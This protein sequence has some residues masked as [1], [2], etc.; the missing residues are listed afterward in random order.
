MD[1]DFLFP[2]PP[3]KRDEQHLPDAIASVHFLTVGDGK[4]MKITYY[5]LEVCNPIAHRD[6]GIVKQRSCSIVSCRPPV[7]HDLLVHCQKQLA[8]AGNAREDR[9]CFASK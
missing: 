6:Q 1:K 5:R 4:E 3:K 7:R 8:L 9:G 2:C